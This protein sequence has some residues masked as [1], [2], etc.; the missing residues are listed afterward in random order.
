[1]AQ[2]ALEAA[3]WNAATVGC[4]VLP[5]LLIIAR[6]GQL[7]LLG[8]GVF[9]IADRVLGLADIAGDAFIAL[10]ADAGR[11]FDRGAGADLGLPF[12]VRLREIVGEVEGGARTVGAAHH[13]DGVGGQLQLSD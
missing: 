6:V 10:G 4:T 5:A 8:V 1:M 9:D 13:G 11:P 7:V 2:S 3:A 12:G